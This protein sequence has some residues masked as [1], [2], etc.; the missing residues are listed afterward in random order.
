M[1]LSS[2]DESKSEQFLKETPVESNELRNLLIEENISSVFSS[3]L[4]RS[5]ANNTSDQSST[6]LSPFN[7]LALLANSIFV[8]ESAS[9]SRTALTSS[10][11]LASSS[12]SMPSSHDDEIQPTLNSQVSNSIPSST[13]PNNTQ[14]AN[15]DLTPNLLTAIR[16]DITKMQQQIN[17]LSKEMNFPKTLMF[18]GT[19]LLVIHAPNFKKYALKVALEIFTTDELVNCVILEENEKK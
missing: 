8:S 19:N 15:L 1:H 2:D 18:N 5:I 13:D 9:T 14:V 17:Q 4:N 7:N 10:S 16:T 3:N 11:V 12:A 6:H